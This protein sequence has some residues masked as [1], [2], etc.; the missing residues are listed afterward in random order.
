MNKII[1]KLEEIKEFKDV[2]KD[3][4]AVVLYGSSVTNRVNKK[5]DVD[6]CLILKSEDEEKI[7]RV[8][9]KVSII[10]G[11]TD[12]YD[13]KIFELLPLKLKF[14][15]IRTGEVLYSKDYGQLQEYFYFFRKIWRDNSANWIKKKGLAN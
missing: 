2:R 4:F 3:V 13:L 12:K 14:E 1:G 7:D 10:M 11:K 15:V 8:F 6:I 5:S 9:R